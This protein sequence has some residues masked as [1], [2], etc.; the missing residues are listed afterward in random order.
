MKTALY[1]IG[2]ATK[3][4]DY[5]ANGQLTIDE[6][7]LKDALNNDPDKVASLFTS[8]DGIAKKMQDVINKNI[9]T[10]G[11][12]GILIAKAGVDNSTTVDDSA[13][14]KIVTDC[15]SKIKDLK[16]L[17]QTQQEQYYAKFTKLEQ[18]LS[19]M[20]SQASLFTSSSSNS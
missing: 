11:G 9:K 3:A 1:Q 5:S 4:N 6:T 16:T 17:L 10:Y 14:T 18:Y 7:K 13:L 8:E 12:D 20:N 19:Q 2:I 15:N